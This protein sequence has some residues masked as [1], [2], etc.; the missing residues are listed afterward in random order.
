MIDGLITC[1]I[2]CARFAI[3]LSRL[4]L[5]KPREIQFEDARNDRRETFG[6]SETIA[7]SGP[8]IFVDKTDD[9]DR[10]LVGGEFEKYRYACIRL[11]M[12]RA[13]D[14]QEGERILSLPLS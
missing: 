2:I 9:F 5:I 12:Y 14:A 6:T 11:R 1:D 13:K 7:L 10:L 4:Q 3:A 8:L